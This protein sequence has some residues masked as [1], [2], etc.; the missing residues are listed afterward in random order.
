[1]GD[2]RL[3]THPENIT[4]TEELSMTS[5]PQDLE[6]VRS[7]AAKQAG[8]KERTRIKEIQSMC[9]RH[10]F[11]D[12]ADQMIENGSSAD[13]CRA[14][15]LERIEAK[16]VEEQLNKKEKEYLARDYKVSALLQG[17]ITGDWS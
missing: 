6:V 8:S 7:E 12:L 17:A 5:T 14:A 2:K 15:I 4:N 10:N 3:N 1:M 13:A 11:G 9:S 16:P